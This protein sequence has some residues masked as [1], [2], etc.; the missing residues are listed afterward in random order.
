VPIPNLIDQIC[1]GSAKVSLEPKHG[2]ARAHGYLLAVAVICIAIGVML[3]HWIEPGVHVEAVVLA[4][5]TPALRF[6][7]ADSGSHPV[8]LMAHGVTAS[9]ETL[10]RFGE[11]LA[12]AGFVCYSVDLP[13]HGES[14]RLFSPMQNADTLTAIARE[15]GSVDVFIGHSMGAGAG[16]ESV[17]NGGLNPR[18]F[19]AVGSVSWLG[20][21]GP[22]VLLLEGRFDEAIPK[23][24]RAGGRWSFPLS[25]DQFDES[26]QLGTNSRVVLFPW[27]DH[28]LEPYDPALVNTAVAAACAKVGKTPPAAPTRWLWRLAGLFLAMPSAFVLALRLPGLFPQL[29]RIRGPVLAGVVILA[30]GLT[31]STWLGTALNPRRV[32]VQIIS[33]V[34]FWLV[35][36]G[37]GRLRVPRWSMVALAALVAVGCVMAGEYLFGLFAGIG[38]TGL[39][40]GM[41]LGEI[42]ARGGTRRD[43]D[44]AMAIFVGYAA[45]QWL[46]LVF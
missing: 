23:Y 35:L 1:C 32:P 17:R 41:V 8:A 29:A 21:A 13:G 15:L 6:S 42:A 45:G 31:S 43:G 36:A 27:C 11:E 24:S 2:S 18:L 25:M 4:G 40:A 19:I 26:L 7:P 3:S 12:M 30:F 20:E 28:A 34:C 37:A 14:R 22:P 46:P 5:D 10:F 38:A 44:L 9:K 39:F 33:I 16:A